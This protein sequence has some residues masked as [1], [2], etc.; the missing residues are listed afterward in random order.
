MIFNFF[1]HKDKKNPPKIFEGRFITDD[2]I[3]EIVRPQ[4]GTFI[5]KEFEEINEMMEKVKHY[6]E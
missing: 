1:K 3:E 5:K 4:T 6:I 2:E